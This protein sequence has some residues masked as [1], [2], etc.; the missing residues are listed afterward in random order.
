MKNL[1]SCLDKLNVMDK[2][3]KCL[4]IL[5]E[6]FPFISVLYLFIFFR[7]CLPFILYSLSVILF[8]LSVWMTIFCF[9]YSSVWYPLCLSVSMYTNHVVCDYFLSV[10]T[11]VCLSVC[12]SACL[13]ICHCVSSNRTPSMT[14]RLTAWGSTLR[15]SPLQ[16]SFYVGRTSATLSSAHLI[17]LTISL[18]DWS[19]IYVPNMSSN[20]FVVF[21]ILKMPLMN[22]DLSKDFL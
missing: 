13:C 10:L 8:H 11:S 16:I 22:R 15:D 21:A 20:I 3:R 17:Q 2:V 19:L 4:I 18:Y 1:I 7:L 12:L 6:S 14:L 9:T 5:L